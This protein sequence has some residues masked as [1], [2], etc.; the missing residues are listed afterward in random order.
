MSL[1]LHSID[2]PR[3]SLSKLT[4]KECEYVARLR[5]IDG[6]E[7]G[8][9]QPLMVRVLRQ[10]GVTGIRSVVDRGLGAQRAR[11]PAYEDWVEI[12][13][14]KVVP[15]KPVEQEVVEANAEDELAAAWEREKSPHDQKPL[16]KMTVFE[17]RSVAKKRGFSPAR[18]S[19]K[20]ELLEMLG[21]KDPS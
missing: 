20:V 1:K 7:P 14:G 5:G 4:R 8:M 6:V 17:L 9:P 10:N 3:D 15:Q 21:G 16:E 19:K 12:V 13:T 18:T 11:L 2:D